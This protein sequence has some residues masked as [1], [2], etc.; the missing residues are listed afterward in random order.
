MFVY[1]VYDDLLSKSCISYDEYLIFIYYF[2]NSISLGSL[3]NRIVTSSGHITTMAGLGNSG[4]SNKQVV[5]N[6]SQLGGT[7]RTQPMVVTQP[8]VQ[9][10]QVRTVQLKQAQ[11]TQ[12]QN[13]GV[14]QIPYV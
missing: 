11:Q 14:S 8:V 6:T 9:T 5:V 3:S 7:L 4:N 2:Q 10:Q 1:F 13:S 12:S